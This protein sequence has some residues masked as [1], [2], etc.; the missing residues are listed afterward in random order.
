MDPLHLMAQVAPP[1]RATLPAA[2]VDVLRGLTAELL[3]AR[4][5]APAEHRR[6]AAVRHR[7]ISPPAVP[8]A[9]AVTGR[10]VLVTG[11]T[12]C[13]GQALLTRLA[14]LRPGRL[15]S[16]A[17]LP[18][19]RPVPGVRYEH[20]DVRDAAL[21][22]RM[23]AHH[24]PQVVFHLAAERAPG[25][26][27]AEPAA[28]LATNLIGTRN[29]LA[30]AERA[31]VRRFV[32][33]STGKAMRPYTPDVYA[34]SKR[35]GESL[36]AGVAA[37]GTTACSGVRFTHVVDNSIIARRLRAWCD[38]GDVVRL[39]DP[40]TMFYVQSA[41]ESAQLLLTALTAP[42]DDVYRTYAIRDLGWPVGLLD[43]ALG[44]MA[45]R[46]T[47]APLYLAGPEP[48]YEC[49]AYPGLFDP[50]YAGGISPLINA[51]EAPSARP[52]ACPQAD[53]VPMPRTPAGWRDGLADLE[54]ACATG[55]DATARRVH[56][57]LCGRA[58]AETAEAAPPA[59]LR[60]I[61]RLTE[62]HRPSMPDGHRVIDD[63]LRAALAR[64]EPAL[65]A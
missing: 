62:P 32:Y 39:H 63:A 10:A 26:A 28:A 5:G 36:V 60:R 53:V 30:A 58:L 42:P 48:G 21:V 40:D 35:L 64:H 59:V 8:V 38:R 6:F 11:G 20:G 7:S 34:G 4:P 24:R 51:L 29:V 45:A 1:G 56:R 9:Q 13:V 3:A 49:S 23:L 54:R 50:R 31:G 46:R 43:L 44:A 16:V 19:Q 41:G 15:V 37:R 65:A 17:H 33:A 25:R 47:V 2:T 18:P 27:E 12:G 55:D 22:R 52:S 61:T 57:D 14:A